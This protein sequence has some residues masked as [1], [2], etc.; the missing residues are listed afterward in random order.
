M[1]SPPIVISLDKIKHS[2]S[3]HFPAGN[4]F[5]VDAILDSSLG[6]P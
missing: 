5:T 6:N 1:I 3:H 2:Y 4:A